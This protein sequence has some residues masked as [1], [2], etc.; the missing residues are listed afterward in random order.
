MVDSFKYQPRASRSRVVFTSLI[1][2]YLLAVSW[3]PASLQAEELTYR[4]EDGSFT[5]DADAGCAAY[6][7]QGSV[8]V[9]PDGRPPSAIRDQ[10]RADTTTMTAVL[11][12]PAGKISKSDPT[13]CDLYEEWQILRRTTSGGSVFLHGRDL[14][15]WRALSRLFL[16]VGTP[17]CEG[18]LPVQAA[19]VSR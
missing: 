12:P 4:C 17:R 14:A 6:E 2:G 5:N 11:P 1:V 3:V 19:H 16:T 18:R 7:P 15:R 8:T 10:L 9:S 13:L